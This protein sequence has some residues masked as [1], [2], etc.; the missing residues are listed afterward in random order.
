VR[1]QRAAATLARRKPDFAAGK[2]QQLHRRA[3]RLRIEDRHDAADEESNS[4]PAWTD[5][6]RDIAVGTVELR[7]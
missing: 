6:R 4:E 7:P 3:V 5:R 1:E 2:L